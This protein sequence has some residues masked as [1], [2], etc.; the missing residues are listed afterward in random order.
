V[1]PRFH[2][3]SKSERNALMWSC[4]RRKLETQKHSRHRLSQLAIHFRQVYWCLRVLAYA[5][6]ENLKIRA[7]IAILLAFS[8]LEWLWRPRNNASCPKSDTQPAV[9]S[10][11]KKVDAPNTS[12]DHLKPCTNPNLNILN[13]S[14]GVRMPMLLFL[15]F[16]AI[17][18]FGWFQSLVLHLPVLFNGG[19]G[20]Q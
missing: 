11:A 10:N 7:M 16:G 8:G 2:L 17:G 5:L 6:R 14:N 20:G 12:A 9:L 1:K 13:K 19:G 18:H 15:P 4:R 3:P